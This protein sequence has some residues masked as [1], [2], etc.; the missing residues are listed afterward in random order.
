M[1]VMAGHR[2][3]CIVASIFVLLILRQGVAAEAPQTASG[4]RFALLIGVDDYAPSPEKSGRVT[5]LKGPANDVALVKQLL[6]SQYKFADDAAHVVTLIGKQA[7]REAILK[8]FKSHLIERAATHPQSTI[9]FYFSGHGAKFSPGDGS[10]HSTLV[11]YDSRASGG[12]DIVDNELI[13]L[14]DELRKYTSNI[15]FILDSCHSGS[16][17]KGIDSPTLTSRSAPPNP[18]QFRPGDRVD[19]P[20]RKSGE[21]TGS[22]L[23]RRQQFALLSAS[24]AEE[25]SY[26]DRIDTT[27]GKRFHGFFTF[28]LVQV[29]NSQPAATVELTMRDVGLS[30]A[31]TLPYQHPQAV[32]RIEGRIFGDA[33]DREDPYVKIVSQP[34]NGSFEIATGRTLGLSDGAFLA[35]YAPTAKRLTGEKDKIAN[36]QI[37]KLGDVRSTATVSGPVTKPFGQDAKVTIVAPYLG[38]E[39]LRINVSELPGQQMTGDDAGLLHQLS[40]ALSNDQWVRPAGRNETWNVAIRRGCADDGKLVLSSERK[41]V[42]KDC[43]AVYYLT[44]KGDSPLFQFFVAAASQS[45]VADLVDRIKR[46]ARQENLRAMDNKSS[47]FREQ[48]QVGVTKVDLEAGSGPEPVIIQKPADGADTAEPM[49]IDQRF[50]VEVRNNSDREL[51]AAVF[52]LGS[53]GNT[54]LITSN[55]NGDLVHAHSKMVMHSPRKIGPPLGRESYKVIATTVSSVDFRLLEPIPGAKGEGGS[56][57]EFYQRRAIGGAAKDSS[58]VDLDSWATAI[59]DVVVVP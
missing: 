20:A 40:E 41:K 59:V 53:S 21:A 9:V 30:L 52:M 55:P 27:S 56:L 24:H 8:T 28:Y 46:F 1:L 58:P 16:A 45:R 54:E 4:E 43:T 44:E 33:S 57:F 12:K 35:I 38:S 5:P 18:H 34:A 23:T 31:R 32:G 17:I 25:L 10:T 22:F 42:T 7:T 49:R 26:E 14:F 29:L 19:G 36:A 51:Y 47:P 15:T 13:D 48:V 6:V 37:S 11:A 3:L 39:K 50:Q 2:I